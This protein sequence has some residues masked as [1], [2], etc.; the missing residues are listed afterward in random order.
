MQIRKE[1]SLL[2]VWLTDLRNSTHQI[3]RQASGHGASKEIIK[4]LAESRPA[5]EPSPRPDLNREALR[6]EILSLLC[7]PVSPR[8]VTV[9]RLP[10]TNPFQANQSG[11]DGPCVPV[12]SPKHKRPC[13]CVTFA[14]STA[15]FN[16]G[17]SIVPSQ[18]PAP[19]PGGKTTAGR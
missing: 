6:R 10:F 5:F 8:G 19:R 18:R 14:L 9:P 7:L 2:H 11:S 17:P 3:D 15:D 1:R 12:A 13:N 4:A 16:P